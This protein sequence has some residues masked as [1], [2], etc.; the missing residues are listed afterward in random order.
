MWIGI[1]ANS[2]NDPDVFRRG[3]KLT[4]VYLVPFFLLTC[5]T[6]PFLLGLFE[7]FSLQV[8]PL[9]EVVC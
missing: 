1:K 3:K 7:I 6:F 4:N 5:I 9:A 8:T 2:L